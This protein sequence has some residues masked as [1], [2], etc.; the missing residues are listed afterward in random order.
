MFRY[1]FWP[2]KVN[3]AIAGFGVSP[4]EFD[5][6]FRTEVQALGINASLTA[7]ETAL[8]L[9]SLKIGK[10]IDQ[11]SGSFELV[12]SYLENA[13]KVDVAKP[14]VVDA[15]WE[16]GYREYPHWEYDAMMVFEGELDAEE[17]P[18]RQLEIGKNRKILVKIEY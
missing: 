6:D 3:A 14:E 11:Y 8:I 2:W 16:M 12:L 9:I 13:G 5:G 18:N 7:Q 10:W 15:L 1:I 4:G 17:L